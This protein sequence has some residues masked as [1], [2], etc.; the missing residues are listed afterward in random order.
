MYILKYGW[1]VKIIYLNSFYMVLYDLVPSGRPAPS[2]FRS[3]GVRL[4]P[5]TSFRVLS[6]PFGS[7][8][9]LSE[10]FRSFQVLLGPFR[11]FQVL[12]GPFRS[13]QV[14][15]G[16]FRSFRVHPINKLNCKILFGRR[17]EI[18][19]VTRGQ[20]SLT[21]HAFWHS[22]LHQV[23]KKSVLYVF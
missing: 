18:W 12:S 4:G 3:S 5:F 1:V 14:L 19:A 6:G 15:S 9:V 21:F 17:S 11:S 22:E 23:F 2:P 7:F 20:K 8:R 13:F 16:P 10:P